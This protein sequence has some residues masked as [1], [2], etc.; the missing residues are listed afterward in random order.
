LELKLQESEKLAAKA[1]EEKEAVL[2]EHSE[3]M[4]QELTLLEDQLQ[5]KENEMEQLRQ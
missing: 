5:K 2:Q 1:V 4:Q 3:K